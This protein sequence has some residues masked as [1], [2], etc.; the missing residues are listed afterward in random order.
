M[1]SYAYGAGGSEGATSCGG[2]AGVVTLWAGVEGLEGSAVG[3]PADWAW[4]D[5]AL[6]GVLGAVPFA[7]P[8][9]D[10]PSCLPDR[11]PFRPLVL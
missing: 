3:V 6:A 2:G 7:G 1:Y 5:E 9:G 4:R 10:C 8:E 11:R